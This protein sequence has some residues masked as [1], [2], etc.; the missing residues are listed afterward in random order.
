[1]PKRE[2][3]AKEEKEATVR[4]FPEDIPHVGAKEK[5]LVALGK[6]FPEVGKEDPE[7]ERI[8]QQV[9][10]SANY[11]RY[12]KQYEGDAPDIILGKAMEAFG[13]KEG[14]DNRLELYA[15][16]QAAH[17]ALQEAHEEVLRENREAIDGEELY[18][19]IFKDL[20]EGVETGVGGI[21]PTKMVPGPRALV[22]RVTRDVSK[23]FGVPPDLRKRPVVETFKR[24]MRLGVQYHFAKYWH[25][26]A[27]GKKLDRDT[28]DVAIEKRY[29]P[30]TV[31]D[32]GFYGFERGQ[33]DYRAAGLG[34]V[35]EAIESGAP[36]EARFEMCRLHEFLQNGLLPH[37]REKIKT[38]DGEI[39][40]EELQRVQGWISRIGSRSSRGEVFHKQVRNYPPDDAM[41]ASL[42]GEISNYLTERREALELQDAKLTAR[43]ERE[44]GS[45]RQELKEKLSRLEEV[46]ITLGDTGVLAQ[47]VTDRRAEREAAQNSLLELFDDDIKEFVG[48]GTLKNPQGR[49]VEIEEVIAYKQRVYAKPV[50]EM[51]AMMKYVEGNLPPVP[52][53][54][55][56]LSSEDEVAEVDDL[57]E[58][59]IGFITDLAR[60]EEHKASLEHLNELAGIGKVKGETVAH[61]RERLEDAARPFKKDLEMYLPYGLEDAAL[62]ARELKEKE[63]KRM[64]LAESVARAKAEELAALAKEKE[65]KAA[66]AAA[67]KSPAENVTQELTAALEAMLRVVGLGAGKAASEGDIAAI[68]KVLKR[69]PET[70]YTPE[71][72]TKLRTKL[73]EPMPVSRRGAGPEIEAERTGRLKTLFELLRI[74]SELFN[75][76]IGSG[77]V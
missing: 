2:T 32:S 71:R 47:D 6:Q 64:E 74:F 41:A 4:E 73:E 5:L 12:R 21:A 16:M 68:E 3:P 24:F 53:E 61:L 29:Y 43:G 65:L 39:E 58:K 48:E 60:L 8:R 57:R 37:W 13:K 20:H 31:A 44:S 38:F 56:A 25:A 9:R 50:R 11:Q 49:V 33:E 55:S 69:V 62:I 14:I 35:L 40:R 15:C 51:Q 27:Y 76:T 36:T 45:K 30:P 72:R 18:L 67:A 7:A 54:I 70:S 75:V 59:Y 1:M 22:D 17:D 52:P 26:W 34:L 23:A 66:E 42:R 77:T 19:S 28:W 63:K 46:A 10:G